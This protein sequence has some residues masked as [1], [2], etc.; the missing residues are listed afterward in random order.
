MPINNKF[1][2]QK[3]VANE[4]GEANRNIECKTAADYFAFGKTKVCTENK[5]LHHCNNNFDKSITNLLQPN[6]DPP[7]ATQ[8]VTLVHVKL[9]TYRC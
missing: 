6:F 8:L 2:Y 3:W 9:S 1:A 7:T 5:L 4:Y